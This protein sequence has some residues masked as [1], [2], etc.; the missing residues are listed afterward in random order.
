[1]PEETAPQKAPPSTKDF[2]VLVVD[3]QE[4]VVR[5]IAQLVAKRA[6]VRP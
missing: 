6:F 1:M 4:E 5:A 3:D 2:R